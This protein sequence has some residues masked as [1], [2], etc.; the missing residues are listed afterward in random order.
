MNRD[1]SQYL[2]EDDKDEIVEKQDDIGTQS[3]DWSQYLVE[4]Q[5]SIPPEQDQI[6]QPP[7]EEEKISPF[8]GTKA[9]L[10]ALTLG[11]SENIP[12]LSLSKAE[13]ENL[14]ASDKTFEFL[15]GFLP[16]EG[17]VKLIAN[18]ITNRTAKWAAASPY[19]KKT[20]QAA[21]R[22]F[23]IGT[24]GAAIKGTE[25][26]F[27]GELPSI[28]EMV[29]DG[30]M[31]AV[32]DGAL[33]TLGYGGRFAKS[34][35]SKAKK[36]N[37]PKEKVLKDVI[38]KLRKS[39]IELGENERTA[40]AALDILEGIEKTPTKATVSAQ[41]LKTRKIDKKS[42][43]E[44]LDKSFELSQEIPKDLDADKVFKA[45]AQEGIVSD[46]ALDIIGKRA[47]TDKVLGQ[48]IKNGIDFEI[49]KAKQVY[50][51]L[52]NFAKDVAKGIE[53]NPVEVVKV[54]DAVEKKIRGL[55]TKSSGYATVLNTLQDARTDLG[56]TL[57]PG[58]KGASY[59]L[60]ENI[61]VS[62]AL[63]LKRRLSDII[64]YDL[65]DYNIKQELIP[66]VNS[67]RTFIK[68]SLGTHN[69]EAA[70][71]WSTAEKE[72]SKY[73]RRFK[74]KNIREIRGETQP[75]RI[76]NK[77]SNPSILEDLKKTLPEETYA[78]VEREV[79]EQIQGDALPA[80]KKKVRNL[81][82]SLSKNANEIAQRIEK[83]KTPSPKRSAVKKIEDSIVEDLSLS[84]EK[85][86]RPSKTLDLW[87]TEKG[88]KIVNNVLKDSPNKAEIVD[89]LNKQTLGDITKSVLDKKG[90]V[91]FS[92][93]N[94]LVRDKESKAL[95][96]RIGGDDA[97][98]FFSQLEQ[99]AKQ[100]EKNLKSQ[101]TIFEG[102]RA[103][104]EYKP[105]YGEQ[106]IEKTYPKKKDP[107]GLMEG[108]LKSVGIN[109]PYKLKYL[110]YG[111]GA[112]GTLPV[113]LSAPK[114]VG[115]YI[116]AALL[117][118]LIKKPKVMKAFRDASSKGVSN[119][120]MAQ[121]LKI[122]DDALQEED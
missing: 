70:S 47:K 31:W 50:A 119:R 114:T 93:V 98:Q 66:V 56:R 107:F 54:I 109:S 42:T 112:L 1:W 4:G 110:I 22:L 19:G 99:R 51:P 14:S 101:S 20:L 104:K 67:L 29:E 122:I 49:Q 63:E 34:L 77:V 32:L 12:G 121:S 52:Y 35:L 24:T 18:P 58:S 91:D 102:K 25:T 76:A 117:F 7:Q 62:K 30:A 81:S 41:D 60:T 97:V 40:M 95:L 44:L 80:A 59:E 61:S 65:L 6:A 28:E 83:N 108:Y 46:E 10:S 68:D 82:N 84:L 103:Q 16:I 2:V 69:K 23:G 89:Y 27:K 21:G 11:L 87:R 85:G 75:E 57:I 113:A 116:T 55:E 33:S 26:A 71:L 13:R 5:E 38:D 88:N 53:V 72:Y 92:K 115:G 15:A 105:E 43:E 39:G 79:L 120:T 96:K 48:S 64:T 74:N 106:L 111:L 78:Q 9:G 36:L 94:K 90:V 45:R 86:E 8:K 73:A 100:L 3:R 37:K 118:K 17:A